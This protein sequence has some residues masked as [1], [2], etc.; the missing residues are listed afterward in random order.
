M[1][2][3]W[4]VA[5]SFAA[6]VG[7]PWTFITGNVSFLYRVSMWSALAGVRLAGVRVQTQGLEKIDPARTYIYMSNHVSNLDPPIL[8]PLIPRRTSV[9]AK[10][11]LFSYP[12]LGKAMKLGSLVPVDRG[13]RD[14]GIAAVREAS[15]VLQQGISMSIF[16]EGKRSFDGKLLPFK[17][18]PFYLA[19]ENNVP[20]VPV[21]ITGTH[22][23]M[24]KRRFSLKPG[25]VKIIFHDPIEPK[26]FG[27]R[28]QLMMKVREVINNGL[29]PECQDNGVLTVNETKD[30]EDDAQSA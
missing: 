20:V 17:K 5:S 18:G 12:V 27:S 16:V 4:T 2:L 13:N 8:L 6:L 19:V 23:V 29:P 30:H 11:E 3:F 14:A 28:D 15:A 24:P 25:T 21:T 7:F 22:Y 1:L 10:K 26:D 9:M